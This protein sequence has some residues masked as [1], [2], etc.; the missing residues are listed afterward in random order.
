MTY[1]EHTTV[2]VEKSRAEIE[3]LIGRYGATHFAYM[4]GPGKSVIEFLASDRRVRFVLPLPDPTDKKFTHKVDGR[5]GT[6]KTRSSD[7]AYRAWEQACRQ[8]WR[9]LCLAVKA[10]L[11]TVRAGISSFESEFLAHIVDPATNRTVGEVMLPILAQSYDAIGESRPLA[12][13]YEEAKP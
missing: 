2:S 9:A 10:K 13:S 7:D 1:A 8:R 6:L 5:S 3:Y 12:I 4:N 11:E